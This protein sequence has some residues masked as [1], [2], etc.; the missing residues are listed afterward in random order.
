MLA[1]GDKHLTHLDLC[2]KF[3]VTWKH[4]GQ[5]KVIPLGKGFYEY[6]ENSILGVHTCLPL[7]YWQSKAIFSIV[8]GID[9]PLSIDDYTKNKYRGFFAC[10]WFVI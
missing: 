1:K 9:T 2:K 4:L 7:E 6:H 3:D 10:G 8:C 5:W